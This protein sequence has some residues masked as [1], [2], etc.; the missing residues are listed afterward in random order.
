MQVLFRCIHNFYLKVTLILF[1]LL[2]SYG[3]TKS[4]RIFREFSP[5]S[6]EDVGLVKRFFPSYLQV[7]PWGPALKLPSHRER[8]AFKDVSGKLQTSRPSVSD[9][10]QA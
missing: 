10:C 2:S 3:L 9:H 7:N 1:L 6:N 4:E 8:F 5:S